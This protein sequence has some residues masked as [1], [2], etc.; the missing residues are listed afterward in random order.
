M[1]N[2]PLVFIL[3]IGS[4]AF[5]A[6]SFIPSIDIQKRHYRNGFSVHLSHKKQL[7]KDTA[8][9]EMF[10]QHFSPSE[11]EKKKSHHATTAIA[12][13]TGTQRVN[14][15]T[16]RKKTFRVSSPFLKNQS[17][18]QPATYLPKKTNDESPLLNLLLSILGCL[19]FPFIAIA[20]LAYVHIDSGKWYFWPIMLLAV[21]ALIAWALAII[22]LLSGVSIALSLL[23][24]V[25]FVVVSLICMI[26]NK[27]KDKQ[28]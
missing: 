15:E 24:Y 13:G 27:I 7:P 14:K 9:K 12:P 17:P 26:I 3:L 19:V 23:I 1:K 8:Q 18:Q 4:Y 25:P 20:I 10:V 2:F 28:L 11:I 16:I 22:L 21:F 6:C 5:S